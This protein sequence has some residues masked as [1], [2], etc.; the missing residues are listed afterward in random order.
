MKRVASN[1]ICDDGQFMRQVW[2]Q[3]LLRLGGCATKFFAA[4]QCLSG[5]FRPCYE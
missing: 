1:Q 2:G 4:T 3:S 5:A